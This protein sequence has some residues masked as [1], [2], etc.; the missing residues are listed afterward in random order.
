MN[1]ESANLRHNRIVTAIATLM[2]EHKK[3]KV[4][5]VAE[6]NKETNGTKP[7]LEC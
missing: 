4:V 1:K 3:C 7:D 6:D 5:C 2:S